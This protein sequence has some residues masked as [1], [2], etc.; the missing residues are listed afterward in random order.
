MSFSIQYHSKFE[1]GNFYHVI[2]KA[3]DGV[4][5]FANDENK[6]YFLRRFA[7]YIPAFADVYAYCLLDNHIHCMVKPKPDEEIDSYLKSIGDENLTITQKRFLAD[8]NRF[9]F[10]E[11]IETQFN[12]LFVSYVRSFNKMYQRKGGMFNKPFRCIEVE[13]DAHFSQLIIYIHAN[14]LKHKLTNDFT[15]YH[16]SSYQTFISNSQTLI[17]REEVLEWFGGRQRFIE[18]H[19]TQADFYYKHNLSGE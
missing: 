13:D 6:L 18:A 10:N 19:T 9:D 12:Y 4:K 17:K 14:P 7:A 5:L 2:A 16:W 11:L 15:Q 1:P 8:K 3:V